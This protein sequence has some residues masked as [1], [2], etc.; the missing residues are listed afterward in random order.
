MAFPGNNKSSAT[1]LVRCGRNHRVP[2]DRFRIDEETPVSHSGGHGR[3]VRG[4][5][6]VDYKL[7]R[8]Q[9]AERRATHQ[10][11]IAFE[12][13]FMVPANLTAL[14]QRARY[15]ALWHGKRIAAEEK[16]RLAV[17]DTSKKP[18]SPDI[19]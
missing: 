6:A 7:S 18:D 19:E 2:R 3:V 9:C 8:Q 1:A 12:P 4:G 14:E 13:S 11:F 10:A 5:P 16:R 15:V 17:S